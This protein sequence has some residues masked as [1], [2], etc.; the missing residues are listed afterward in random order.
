M[1][2]DFGADVVKVEPPAGDGMRYA[3]TQV[4]VPDGNGNY[5]RQ[6]ATERGEFVDMVFQQENRNKRSVAVALGTPSGQ[7]VI[8]RLLQTADVLVTNLLPSRLEKYRLDQATLTALNPRLIVAAV[9]AYGDDGSDKDLPGFDGGAFF[10]RGGHMSVLGSPGAEPIL[11]RAGQ[12]DH[13]TGLA[14][15]SA[16]LG[17][18]LLREKTGAGTSVSTSL[19]RSS[20][21]VLATDMSTVLND[22]IQ[23]PPANVPRER[24]PVTGGLF[25]TADERWIRLTQT[26]WLPLTIA[27]GRREL[28]D[29]E[30][31]A[32]V[33]ARAKNSA[34]LLSLLDAIFLT[35]TLAE[36]DLA[37]RA[38]G[39]KFAPVATLAEAAT[40]PQVEASGA[41]LTVPHPDGPAQAPM[42]MVAAPF[43]IDNA[44][45]VPARAAPELGEHTVDVLTE[46]GFR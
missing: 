15:L 32:T 18:L 4:G 7:A 16:I 38:A 13:P 30:L 44:G 37:L 5:R 11:P 34:A 3:L 1:L 10:A 39:C 40:D 27:I 46:V 43:R 9:S 35:K 29:D 28:A 45:A 33:P 8:H 21:F 19:L 25:K 31:F 23:P 14:L 24:R 26:E 2:A 36:W 6:R 22:G 12:G 41:I 42:R 20:Q 17:A